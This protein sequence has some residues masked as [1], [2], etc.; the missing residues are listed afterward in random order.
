MVMKRIITKYEMY[1]YIYIFYYLT[2]VLLLF[3]KNR[4]PFWSQR[5]NGSFGFYYYSCLSTGFFG[6]DF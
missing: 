1:I 5:Q 2:A 4:V 6:I 3:W